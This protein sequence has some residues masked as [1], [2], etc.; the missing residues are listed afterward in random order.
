ME[1]R[2]V[3]VASD[4]GSQL[5]QLGTKAK[6]WFRAAD[7]TRTLFKEGYPGSGE[8]WAEK[9]ACEVARGLNLPHADYELAV[10]N[11][12]PGVVSPTIVP[13]GGQLIHGNELLART[14]AGYDAKPVPSQ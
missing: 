6:F 3:T 8:H 2:I 14:H 13:T 5:E 11:Q 7:G 1:Y 12:R 9:L 4:A 10:W